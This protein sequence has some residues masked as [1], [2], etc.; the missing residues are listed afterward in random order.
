MSGRLRQRLVVVSVAM[1]WQH[2][3]NSSP[4]RSQQDAVTGDDESAEESAASGGCRT[5]IRSDE[6]ATL[7]R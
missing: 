6:V 7:V 1:F 2:R 5:Q 3:V 4:R